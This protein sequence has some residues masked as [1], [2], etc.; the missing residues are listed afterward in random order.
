[1][2]EIK[3]T[4]V[5]KEHV[6][7]IWP[8]VERFMDMA[9]EYTYGRYDT[10]DILTAITDYDHHL[11]VAFNV[12]GPLLGAVVTSFRYY[13]KKKYLDLTFLGGDSGFSW[14]DPM[15]KV[16][17]HWAYDNECDGIESS[18]RPGW[19]KVFKEDGYKMLWQTYELPVAS[20]GLGD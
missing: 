4:L 9:A 18:G 20:S 15:L 2:S 16:L 14:K 6:L 3:A 13:P 19:S 10:D 17:Q 7:T 1:V 8:Q 5:P 12:G 11:W